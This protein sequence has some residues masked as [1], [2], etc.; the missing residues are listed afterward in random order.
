MFQRL[1][2][3]LAAFLC[4][5]LPVATAQEKAITLYAAPALA[6]S[7]LPNYLL[8]RF[9]LKTGIGIRPADTPDAADV[10]LLP[11]PQQGVPA[12]RRRADGAL[13]GV[14]LGPSGAD[15]AAGARAEQFADWL[16]S[17]IGQRTVAAFAPGETALFEGAA[18]RTA[19]QEEAVFEGDAVLGKALS[20]RHCGRCHVVAPENRMKGLGSTPSFAALKALRDWQHRFQ[21]FHVL[22]PHPAFT[23]I[24]EVSPPFD[25]MRPSPIAPMELT[26]GEV[27]AILAFVSGIAPADLG[28]PVLSR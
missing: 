18:G 13:F 26:Q 19:T 8:P 2:T 23:Q 16:L 28:A 24:A 15:T 1:A 4:L 12:L 25:P 10:A 9:S 22:N 21:V 20:L 17:D 27:D 14:A 5:G 3:L 11:A 6:E 7:G